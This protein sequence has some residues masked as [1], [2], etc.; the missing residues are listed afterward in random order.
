MRYLVHCT[1]LII[2]RA[3]MMIRK[4]LNDI[5]TREVVQPTSTNGWPEFRL[6][7]S[8]QFEYV[9]WMMLLMGLLQAMKQ[10]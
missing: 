3:L 7:G 9:G 5:K 1:L 8:G 10:L 6:S 2:P 4:M